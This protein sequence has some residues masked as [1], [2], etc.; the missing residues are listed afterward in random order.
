M[1]FDITETRPFRAMAIIQL[2]VAV[3][4]ATCVAWFW[5]TISHAY[6]GFSFSELGTCLNPKNEYKDK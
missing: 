1:K 6:R 3:S 4:L 2:I 5:L